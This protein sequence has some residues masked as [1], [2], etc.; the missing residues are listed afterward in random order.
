[1]DSKDVIW[2]IKYRYE[3]GGKCEKTKA[4]EDR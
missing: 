4:E 2:R 3:K 1:M